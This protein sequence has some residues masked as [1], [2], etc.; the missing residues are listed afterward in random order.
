MLQ[1]LIADWRCQQLQVY[2]TWLIMERLRRQFVREGCQ[3]SASI[4]RDQLCLIK[5][6]IT[7]E[8]FHQRI[9]RHEAK[10]RERTYNRLVNL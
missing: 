6:D 9:Q 7:L 3:Q 2:R 10:D 8:E 4:M 1:A 5:L